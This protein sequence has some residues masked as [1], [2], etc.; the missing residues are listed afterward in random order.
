MKCWFVYMMTNKNNTVIYT[1]ITDNIEERV[2]EH[3][4]KKFPKSF[5]ARYNCDKLI[6]FEEI[7]KGAMAMKRERQIKKWKRA[8]KINLIEEMNPEWFDLSKNWNL[9]TKLERFGR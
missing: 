2:K 9:N 6:Y 8:W 4:L 7:G 5:T 3:Q 1:D